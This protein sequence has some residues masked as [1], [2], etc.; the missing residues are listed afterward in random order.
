LGKWRKKLS[1][2]QLTRV[3]GKTAVKTMVVRYHKAYTA[4]V[5][6]EC[7][8]C[9][10]TD[11]RSVHHGVESPYL[12]LGRRKRKP[13]VQFFYDDKVNSVTPSWIRVALTS[14][15]PSSLQSAPCGPG[16]ITA[17][18]TVQAVV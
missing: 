6:V 11:D 16:T 12:E 8:F 4:V 2:Y 9:Y 15:L 18:M 7:V 17:C 10:I 14:V 1:K 5:V 13:P 3:A